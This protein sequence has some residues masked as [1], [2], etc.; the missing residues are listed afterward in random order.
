MPDKE[1]KN[2]L[3][4][5][6]E[7]LINFFN[8]FKEGFIAKDRYERWAFVKFP[9]F[10]EFCE[11]E[12]IGD[13]W[14]EYIISPIFK[15][16][17]TRAK[18]IQRYILTKGALAGGFNPTFSK[19]YASQIFG[20]NEKEDKSKSVNISISK[21]V[22]ENRKN[23]DLPISDLIDNAKPAILVKSDKKE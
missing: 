17:Y 11:K 16:F 4:A 10:E 23:R 3:A 21:L 12:G 13:E 6:G 20:W 8:E 2:D 14:G 18:N 1:I 15:P 9:T 5:L 7:K 19:L 22:I